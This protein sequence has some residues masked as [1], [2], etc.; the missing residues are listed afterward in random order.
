V[1]SS[2]TKNLSTE[3]GTRFQHSFMSN[4]ILLQPLV[5]IS[6]LR[7]QAIQT[8]D[9]TTLSFSD[10]SDNFSVATSNQTKTY[11]KASIGCVGLL[12]NN[13]TISSF[14]TGKV[15]KHER[16]IELFLKTSYNF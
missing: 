3:I 6:M 10:S 5:S 15:K 16:S 7:E 12:E 14:F 8:Q 1:P 13:I 11:A 2:S 9:N 4:G